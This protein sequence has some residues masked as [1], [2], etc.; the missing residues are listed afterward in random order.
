MVVD[1][2]DEPEVAAAVEAFR[3][4]HGSPPSRSAR[5]RRRSTGQ[6]GPQARRSATAP[7]AP[8][9]A[10]RSPLARRAGYLAPG[11][12]GRRR[13]PQHAA[14]GGAHPPLAVPR[15]QQGIDDLHYEVIV[16]ENGSAPDQRLGDELVRGF[17]PEFRYL[18]LGDEATPSPADALNRG[19]RRAPGHARWPS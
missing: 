3:A 18:D 7:A 2:G 15:Y 19:H 4:A 17:G 16:V 11:P 14:R 6:G 9:A 5:S 13:R 8:P 12:V 10:S 1:D